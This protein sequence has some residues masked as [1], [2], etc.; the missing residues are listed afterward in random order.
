MISTL[1]D[2][3]E[4]ANHRTDLFQR[5]RDLMQRWAEFAT[6]MPG[7]LVPMRA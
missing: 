2:K 4:A 5:R 1:R 7:V 6:Q 3:T